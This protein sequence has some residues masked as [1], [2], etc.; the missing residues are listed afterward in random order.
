M[1]YRCCTANPWHMWWSS[2]PF[3]SDAVMHINE[4]V[5]TAVLEAFM[6]AECQ[7]SAGVF[8]EMSAGVF[9]EIFIKLLEYGGA[10]LTKIS[11]PPPSWFIV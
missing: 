9:G 1:T 3:E 7:V 2:K 8:G 6:K 10:I 5:G 4:R 11:I